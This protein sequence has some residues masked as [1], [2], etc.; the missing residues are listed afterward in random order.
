MQD[1]C[2]R[3]CDIIPAFSLGRTQDL[4]FAMNNIF[5]RI[6]HQCLCDELND[7]MVLVDSP[8]AGR[9]TEIYSQLTEHWGDEAR[10]VLTYDDHPLVFHN[11]IK[12]GDQREHLGIISE[13]LD[14]R[15][16][17]IVIAGSGMCSGGRVVN[18]LKKFLGRPTTDI[19][20]VGYQA[21]GTPGHYIQNRRRLGTTGWQALRHQ[22]GGTHDSWLFGA[23]RPS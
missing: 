16:P 13:L 7:V 12:V 14:T 22:R 19:V 11:L 1:T 9:F 10:H 23:R 8:L 17:A 21:S 2:Q 18:Y 3:R 15:R 4:L 5:E 20:F 6:S